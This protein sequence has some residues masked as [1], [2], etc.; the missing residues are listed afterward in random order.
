[1]QVYDS[2]ERR[3]PVISQLQE[4]Y[5]NRNLLRLLIVRDLTVRYKRSVLGVGWSLLNP[6]LTTTVMFYVFNTVFMKHFEN[7]DTFLPY[8][9]S[10][11]LLSTFFNQGVNFAANSIANG[12]DLFSKVYVRPEIFAL[13]GTISSSINFAFGLIPLT[14]VSFMKGH[15]IGFKGIY[16]IVIVISMIMLTTG[17]GL[18]FAIA[19]IQFDDSKYLIQVFLMLASYMMPVFYTVSALGPNTQNLIEKNPLTSFL[20]AFRD[21]WGSTYNA[22]FFDW[23]YLFA[24]SFILLIVGLYLFSKW[25]PKGVTKL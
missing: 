13:S 15:G 10:G 1:M 12:A 20:N 14:L 2:A 3:I 16:A 5:A 23:F 18:I 9:F 4:I 17:L 21:C 25:W 11:V 7:R 8:L 6:I 19:Y 22:T 24:S